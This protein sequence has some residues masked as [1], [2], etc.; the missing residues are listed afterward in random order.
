MN[1]ICYREFYIYIYLNQNITEGLCFFFFSHSETRWRPTW[2]NIFLSFNSIITL[3][4][5]LWE[6]AKQTISLQNPKVIHFPSIKICVL[7]LPVLRVCA[8]QLHTLAVPRHAK[9]RPKLQT[10]NYK[11]Q[12]IRKHSQ[13]RS[14]SVESFLSK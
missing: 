14:M 3:H 1:H 12:E 8:S 13:F 9:R 2:Y 4:F 7:T 10:T 11:L 6:Q 5:I